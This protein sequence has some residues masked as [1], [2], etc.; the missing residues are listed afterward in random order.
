MA[1]DLHSAHALQRSIDEQFAQLVLLVL[2][3]P[4]CLISVHISE[5]VGLYAFRT[6]TKIESGPAIEEGSRRIRAASHL[7]LICMR[8][9]PCASTSCLHLFEN[10][11][12]FARLVAALACC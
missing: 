2:S 3:L 4:L 5:C 8:K 9:N 12:C 11:G 10:F 7:I 6:P 1:S